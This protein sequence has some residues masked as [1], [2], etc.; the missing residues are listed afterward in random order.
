M[1]K[2]IQI[3]AFLALCVVFFPTN[4]RAEGAV[5][6][7]SASDI[8]Y[9]AVSKELLTVE[10]LL[11]KG[12]LTP[13]QISEAVS[14][15]GETRTSL[16]VIK[17]EIEQE[18]KFVERRIEALGE[19]PQDGEKELPVIAQKRKEFTNELV[20][21]RGKVAEA[22]VLLAK[23]DELEIL[24]L[25]TRNRTLLQNILLQQDSLFYPTA[26]YANTKLFVQ[27]AYDI[28]KSPVT[29]YQNLDKAGT[30]YVRANLLPFVLIVLVALWLGI[31][32]RLWI[33]R[34]FGYNKEI[35][36]PRYGKK[37][38]A[39]IAVAIA[40]GVIPASIIGG[41]LLWMTSTKIMTSGFF[42][43][44]VN[45]FLFYLLLMILAKAVARVVL[46]PYNPAWRLV[47]ANDEKAKHIAWALY[48]SVFLIGIAEFLLHIAK[49]A[50]YEEN[51]LS[52]LTTL[53]CGVKAFCIILITK[54]I[55]WDGLT[56]KEEEEV[57][58]EDVEEDEEENSQA[59]FAFKV[60]FF[61]SLF[62]V[63][64]FMAAPLGYP[65]L[66]AYILDN[67]IVTC[68]ILGIFIILRKSIDEVLHRLLLLRFW[69][70]TFKMRRRVLIKIDF[71]SGLIIDPLLIVGALFGILSLWGVST[72][73]LRQMLYKLL[74]GFKVGGVNISL[75]AIVAG[76]IVFFIGLGIVRA[77]RQR[78]MS[79]VLS[80]MD[81]DDG[82]RHSLA[83]GFGFLGIIMAALLAV[84]VMGVS[85]TNL[86]LIAGAL[87][88]GIGLGL[89]NI[90][91]NFVSG[92]ILLFE[93]PIK[94]GDWVIVNGEEGI[95][96]QINSR[97]TEIETWKKASVIIP[98]ADL[99]SNT[100]TNLTHDDKWGRIEI[101]VGV[102]YDSDIEKVKEI[103]LSV[104]EDH[105]R[106][107]K[108]PAPYV[109]FS[110]FGDSSLDF[111]LRCYT[112]DILNGLS[113]ASDLRTAIYLRFAAEHIEIPFPQQVLH[114]A[115]DEAPIKP[116]KT[117]KRKK[118]IK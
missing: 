49:I 18:L 89:Q 33:M 48:Y 87:S 53:A 52:Y 39:A 107:L 23:L 16:I 67:F 58:V 28:I 60:M 13:E 27:F 30:D 104:A 94:V 105:K 11:K 81:M 31:F 62:A 70:K 36:R 38:M 44:I 34:H 10:K 19:E 108:K 74:F 5:V 68:I 77:L 84:A 80:K 22:D 102:A 83:S 63:G 101:K 85:L 91:N 3:L 54:R 7:S 106:V 2:L 12:K 111:E 17:K 97:A 99:L 51:L 25:N 116:K 75:L 9:P 6:S 42:G 65:Y 98:N 117:G 35:E 73:I 45:S 114:V 14:Y 92:I 1:R 103:L 37:V 88:L 21:K 93:R 118:V 69:T 61:M 50:G 112:S 100:V 43:I 90:V 29:W 26:L 40:Y 95:V 86:A 55:L 46:A 78:L 113:L 32:L 66:S 96:K 109:I 4:L 115:S 24:I 79:N 47:N 20:Q 110:N 72:D 59:D 8:D 56:S 41:F 76:V 57:L 64:A 15:I 82:T 71:W